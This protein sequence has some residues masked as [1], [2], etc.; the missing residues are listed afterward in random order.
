MQVVGLLSESVAETL[1]SFY[2]LRT[3]YKTLEG[4]HTAISA[5]PTD[6]DVDVTMTSTP[7]SRRSTESDDARSSKAASTVSGSGSKEE[8]GITMC[9]PSSKA[10]IASLSKTKSRMARD[11]VEVFTRSG[12]ALC[13]GLLLLLVGMVPPSL[14]RVMTIVGFRGGKRYLSFPQLSI[15]GVDFSQT[16]NGDSRCSGKPRKRTMFMAPLPHW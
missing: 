5:I 10:S 4:I 14:G 7:R 12:C 2:R 15:S 13:F 1:R 6:D 3:A 16:G 9:R 8:E 11:E